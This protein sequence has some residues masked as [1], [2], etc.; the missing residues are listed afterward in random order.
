MIPTLIVKPSDLE[1]LVHRT[2]SAE[3][4][5]IDTEFIWERTYYPILA[6]V[7]VGYADREYIIDVTACRDLSS[8]GSLL[9]AKK[10]VK[11]LHDA[12]QDL[13]I[14]HRAT[15]AFPCNVFDTQCGSGFIGLSATISLGHLVQAALG[16]KLAKTE[17]RTNWLR[18]PLSKRQIAYALNDVRYLPRVR[19]VILSRARK[20][21]FEP[22][23]AQ[24]LKG[25]NTPSQYEE[26]DAYLQYQRIKGTKRFTAVELAILCELAHW[27]EMRA[28]FDDRPRE[29][30]VNDKALAYIAQCKPT[31]VSAL[32]PS[33]NFPTKKIQQYG[34]EIAR[35]V[36]KGLATPLS[37]RPVP[38]KHNG[39][40]EAL[41]ARIDFAM[42][43]IKG[44][45]LSRGIDSTLIGSRSEIAD[46]VR[47]RSSIRS[48]K[49]RLMVG[50]RKDFIGKKLR[51]LLTGKQAIRMNPSTGLPQITPDTNGV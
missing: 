48:Q 30:L 2:L 45:C 13:V 10:V 12:H 47:N 1:Q 28:R 3:C 41:N 36:V 26:K 39:D 32:K 42:A 29:H 14:L 11:I 18:R 27:R 50:W 19:E 38:Y 9:K 6:L 22:W 34:N 8:L 46:F 16:I 15:A 49:H 37:L 20:N 31:T 33:R 51:N 43:Y 7:Q 17:T 35:A 25:Y 24:E 21:G 23:L 40:D 4:V 44:Q 5:A